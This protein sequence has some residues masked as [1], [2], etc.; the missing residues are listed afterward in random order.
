MSE[1]VCKALRSKRLAALALAMC[2]SVALIGAQIPGRNVN[3]VSGDKWP[4][5]DPHL[6]RQNEPSLAASTR[7]PLHLLAGANDYRTVDMPGL[8]GAKETA[9]AWLG[10]FKSFDGGA[11]WKSTLL[12]GYPQDTSADARKSPLYGYQAGADPV[13]RPGPGGLFYYSGIVFD[14]TA[15]GKSRVFVARYIDNN[16]KEAGDPIVYLGATAVASL[17]AGTPSMIDKPWIAVDV[18]R[19]GARNCSIDTAGSRGGRMTQSIP[20]GNVYLAYSVVTGSD[21]DITSTI[22][23][24]KSTDCG[25]TWTR[26]IAISRPADRVNQGATVAVDPS[27]GHVYVAWRKFGVQNDPDAIVIARS[28]NATAFE[29]PTTLRQFYTGRD[30]GQLLRFMMQERRG[31]EVEA[32]TDVDQEVDAFDQ[33]SGTLK[34]KF[35]TNAY[36][37]MAID[38]Q[39]RVYV[40]WSE[41]GF[42]PASQGASDDASIVMTTGVSGASWLQP[43]A[44]DTHDNPGHQFMPSLAFGGGKLM[45]VYYDLR[46]DVSGIFRTFVDEH[47]AIFYGNR[48]HTIDVRA[49][50]A[51]PAATPAFAPSVQISEYVVG[52][53]K[54]SRAIEQLQFNPPNLPLFQLGEVPFIGDYVDIAAAPAMVQDASGQWRHNTAPTSS[55]IFHTAWTDN[56]DVRPPA[57]GDWSRYTPPSTG[58]TNSK[59]DPSQIVPLCES[60]RAGMR[61]QNVYTARIT[62]GLIAGSPG[63]AKPLSPDLP[64][65]FVVFAQ[66]ATTLAK[67]Y[68]LTIQSQPVGGWASFTQ[69]ESEPMVTHVDVLAPPRSMVSRTVFATSTDPRAKI[70]ID[71]REIKSITEPIYV[72]NGLSSAIVL[73]PDIANPDIANPDI[74]NPDIANPDIANPDI[75]NAEVYNPDIAN[76]DIANPDIANPDIANPDIAN[77]DIANV[78]VMNP[79]IANP[80]IANPDIANPD[81]ANPDIANPDIANPD[82]ANGSLTDVTWTVTNRGNTT[83]SYDINLLAASRI[84][85]GIKAQL[86][87]HKTYKT[88]VSDGCTLKTQTQTVLVANVV[89]NP[90][91]ANPDIANPDIANPDIANASLWLEPGGEGKVT[92]RIVDPDPKDAVTFNPISGTTAV[93]PEIQADAVNTADLSEPAPEPPTATPPSVTATTIQV[94]AQPSAGTV[95]LPLGLFRVQ[96]LRTVDGVISPLANAA[97]AAGILVNPGG[98]Q[99]SGT[100]TIVTDASGYADFTSLSID[101]AGQGYQLAFTAS[102]SQA[103][104]V[105]SGAFAVIEPAVDPSQHVF[106]VTTTAD[107]GPGSLRQAIT[108]ANSTP[109][110][111]AGPDLIK[112]GFRVSGTSVIAVPTALPTITEAVVIDGSTQL[113]YN[114]ATGK[115]VIHLA[116]ASFPESSAALR[117]AAIGVVIRGLSLTAFG[118]PASANTTM[119]IHVLSGS[120]T[121]EGN[122]IGVTPDGTASGN[123]VG[124]WVTSGS[125]AIGGTNGVLTRN[126]ISGNRTA[127]VLA[128]GSGTTIRGNYIGTDPTGVAAMPNTVHGIS[129]FGAVQNTTIGGMLPNGG[130]LDAASPTNVIAGNGINSIQLLQSGPA[131][132]TSTSVLG[133]IIGLN[134][135]GDDITHVTSGSGHGIHVNGVAE[136]TVI[137]APGGGNIIS[138]HGR[139]VPAIATGVGILVATSPTI[140]NPPIIQSNFIGTDITGAI[141]RGNVFEGILLTSR[142]IVGGE[143]PGEGNLISGNGLAPNSGT[144]ILVNVNAAGAVIKGNTIGL[145]S[146]GSA[147]G[148]GYSGITVAGTNGVT[149]G[150]SAAGARNVISGNQFAGIAI[151]NNGAAQAQ[152]VTVQGN[153]IGTN[154]SGL[155]AGVG[156]GRHG[157]WV[158]NSSN[159][160]IGGTGAQG[161]VIAGNSTLGGGAGVQVNST[162]ARVN[163]RGNSIFDNNGLGINLG[164]N[165]TVLPNDAGDADTGANGHQNYPILNGAVNPYTNTGYLRVRLDSMPGAYTVQIFNN[166][167]CDPSG[168]GEGQTLLLETIAG[169]GNLPSDQ[170]LEVPQ[171]AAGQIL[172]ATA[173]DANGNTSEFSPCASIGFTSAFYNAATGHFYEYVTAYTPDWN[174]ANAAATAASL[175]GKPG[176]LVTI[177]DAGENAFVQNLR[178]A[179]GLSDMRPWIGLHDPSGTGAW[180]WVT[181]EASNYSN[182]NGGE[183]NNIGSERYVE[184]FAA[185]VWNNNAS[186]FGANQG[187]VIEYQ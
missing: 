149:I 127:I 24:S 14:R 147:L 69:L 138:G 179:M 8:H 113:G 153:Y 5:G 98:G 41:R 118:S 144:G 183:P 91:I 40:A 171:L 46:E 104:P 35:R 7:N 184:F 156:N 29:R 53:R 65:G 128:G 50:Q 135:N 38:A 109:N 33:V 72:T 112:F 4:E 175:L 16:N 105:S 102:A 123:Q 79:D 56:R 129:A 180:Q 13:V 51:N 132:P 176:H 137:G 140:A 26:P 82:I 71:V 52:S 106:L 167:A 66:N 165:N 27:N 63:N 1:A 15:G 158:A 2:T 87:V 75:A 22:M 30:L 177:T 6:Q 116:G 119:A 92:L 80:D 12:P 124:V 150:G 160:L 62:G 154:A 18:P 182:W 186:P 67:Y 110:G 39:N 60:G 11:R 76:P 55:P 126:I 88:P 97:V 164:D 99:L 3:M 83:A 143:N 89:I 61:N 125:A 122:W 21:A 34:D 59:F 172:T 108:D 141:A 9:D 142:A 23:F 84:P 64:R 159:H 170:I 86:I 120:A 19:A 166:T 130:Y 181:G 49:T 111:A 85:Q 20:A 163:I 155:V 161:N 178:V 93:T 187:Y 151:Y 114:P 25:V 185:G 57:D 48:R 94:V 81:I 115:P 17:P 36:P 134:I 68:R 152:N 44:I 78:V 90:D 100:S 136:N 131:A 96:V 31:G 146:T 10:V 157:V 95:S 133:N 145:S 43:F 77:P 103:L 101:R 148:N 32:A 58:Q 73:N 74:A 139:L 169:V 121:I 54:G 37:T 70:P 47:S 45:L 28:Q 107:S 42:R 162:A 173:T 168:N 117:V 174:A